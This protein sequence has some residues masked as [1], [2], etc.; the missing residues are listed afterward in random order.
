MLSRLKPLTVIFKT[1]PYLSLFVATI[2]L[3]GYGAESVPP[4]QESP[5]AATKA[6]VV[7][8]P[9]GTHR[10]WAEAM[11]K[12]RAEYRESTPEKGKRKSDKRAS[13]KS[14]TGE[15]LRNMLTDYPFRSDWLLQ[16]NGNNL[17]GWLNQTGDAAIEK[18]VIKTFQGLEKHFQGLKKPKGGTDDPRWLEL[19]AMAAER[20][21]FQRVEKLKETFPTIGFT[22]NH[23]VQ[24]SFFAY[25]EG[26]SDAQHERHFAPGTALCAAEWD[27]AYLTTRELVNDPY[28]RIRDPEVSFDGK[29]ILFA[30]KKS[31][32]LDDYH[33]YELD[34]ESGKVRQLTFGLGV[35]DFEPCYV[36]SGDIVFSSS[37][38]V[39]TVDCYW[40]E[41]SNLYTCDK[42]GNYLRRLGFDQVHTVKPALL[43][44][45]RVIYTRWDYND[46]GQVY[47]QGLFQMNPDGTG[48]TE[49]Y[50]NNSWYPT[51]ISHARGIPGSSLV[52]ATGHGHHTWQAGELMLIDT[53]KG[54]Q[55]AQGVQLIAPVRKTESVRV[56]RYGQA[57]DLFQYPYPM[58]E[59]EYLVAYSPLGGRPTRF[60]LYYMDIDGNR[61][62]LVSDPSISCQHP[63]PLVERKR[64]SARPSMVDYTKDFGTYYMQDI[65][66]GPGLKGVKRGVIKKLRVV[67]LDF[68]AAGIGSNGSRGP[69]GGALTST[70][71]SI[72]N[73]AWDVKRVVGDAVVHPDGSA[74]F[75]APAQVPLYFQAL[76]EHNRAVQTMRS[77]STLMPGENFSCVG[78]HEDK[79]SA[80]PLQRT[81]MA[82]KAGSQKLKP[83]YGETRGFSF[84][85]E[86]QPILDAKCVSCHNGEKKS[87]KTG[88]PLFSLKNTPVPDKGAMRNWTEAYISL[89]QPDG[90]K[91]SRLL[92]NADGGHCVW[93][94]AQSVPE[95]VPPY[96][97]GAAVSP[98]MDRLLKRQ[99]PYRMT[100]AELDKFA[101]WID[102]GVPFCGDYYEA[103]I[104]TEQA[105]AFYDRYQN[106]RERLADLD[107]QNIKALLVGK[108]IVQPLA[109]RNPYRNIARDAVVTANSEC[110]LE[111]K[112]DM[113]VDRLN[114]YVRADVLPYKQKDHDSW[115]KTGNIEL[116]NGQKIPFKLEKTADVQ[117]VELKVKKW[118]P[119]PIRWLKITNL[120]AAEDKWCGF[121]E[122]EVMGCNAVD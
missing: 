72:G 30:W 22:Q 34:V 55:E 111:W 112:E 52:I 122:V 8:R 81:T 11:L 99:K 96:S 47:P 74:F 57:G 20:R 14:G 43:E 54:R 87:N 103:G 4:S 42:D 95:M 70:P 101:A 104:W 108:P 37:R 16:D 117:V 77:W 31:D 2:C 86:I 63:V 58:N 93:V 39:Q 10:E 97:F 35:A 7:Y 94:S 71:I 98:L 84:L 79:N 9:A 13:K 41:V 65:H 114:L 113:F 40:T 75:E 85:K 110:T 78:C 46:R 62:L 29:K 92:G 68:R 88:E 64:P 51:T 59:R 17:E 6:S 28:G 67:A 118:P 21:R 48:Q 119:K 89:T 121:S 12:L 5:V 116:S 56:D 83:F 61:E 24:P 90:H 1:A 15:V 25:T 36:P 105:T 80:P 38:C 50:G 66:F 23:T 102:L 115:W 18:E 82:M 26:Q 32:R 69:A 53:A 27:G 19:Y 33:L 44:D 91:K 49:F 45:G 100:Q 106:K 73:G 107:H 76:D 120:V 60:S 109:D 3:Q